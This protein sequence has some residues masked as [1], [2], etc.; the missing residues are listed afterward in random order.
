MYLL[1]VAAAATIVVDQAGHG[2]TLTIEEALSLAT[3][4]DTIHIHAG[5]YA[6][7]SM[8]A[9]VDNLTIRGAGPRH[10][11]LDMSSWSSGFGL[12]V[13]GNASI[14]DMGFIGPKSGGTALYYV[15]RFGDDTDVG[16]IRN[17]R[18]EGFE[19]TIYPEGPFETLFVLDSVFAEP[20]WPVYTGFIG[21][22]GPVQFENNVVIDG[23]SIHLEDDYPDYPGEH[24]VVGNTFVRGGCGAYRDGYYGETTLSFVG[25]VVVESSCGT[26]LYEDRGDTVAYNVYSG[27]EGEFIHQARPENTHSNIDADP[28]FCSWSS[29]MALSDMDLRLLE[30]SPAI[31]VLPADYSPSGSD[32]EGGVRPIDG[33][34]DGVA[35]ADAGAYEFDIARICSPRPQDTGFVDSGQP[36]DTA[37]YDTQD[38]SPIDSPA[39]S[40]TESQSTADSR[41]GDSG[42]KPPLPDPKCGCAAAGAWLVLPGLLLVLLGRRRRSLGPTVRAGGPVG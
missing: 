25:N 4:G 17:C 3:D 27:V 11:I 20:G 19:V 14:S 28:Q 26:A 23:N 12:Q 32:N 33:D 39:D 40:L 42:G 7:K 5:V 37:I 35:R 8:V 2:D 38:S 13:S 24:R 34:G 1:S 22:S 30:Y 36:I 41:S 16:V 9:A 31:D 21:K 6:E 29:E 10:T 15:N 18:F